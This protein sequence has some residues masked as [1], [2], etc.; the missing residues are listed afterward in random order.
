M[1]IKSGRFGRFLSCSGFPD[2]RNSR[3]LLKRVG[4]DCPECGNDIV[5]RRGKSK[6]RG[7]KTFYGCS[8]YPDCKFAVNQRPLAQ[9]C[10]DCK[11]MLLASGRTNAR[12]TACE[13]KG[14]APEVETAE[15]AD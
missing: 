5:E 14:P 15:V 4:V 12:C 9:P 6:G 7:P 2:C 1:V 11:G 8:G 10:P 3:P 13:Y